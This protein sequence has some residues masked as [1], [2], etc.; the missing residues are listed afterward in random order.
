MSLSPRC[1]EELGCSWLPRPS[2]ELFYEN[3]GSDW[4][5]LDF[6]I[7]S[8]SCRDIHGCESKSYS[9]P[10]LP[11]KKALASP[12]DSLELDFLNHHEKLLSW[13]QS[14]FVCSKDI[15]VSGGRFLCQLTGCAGWGFWSLES[16]DVTQREVVWV[17]L[18]YCLQ[19]FAA[20]C[21]AA[22]DLEWLL[23]FH[24]SCQ[25][26]RQRAFPPYLHPA[27]SRLWQTNKQT[28]HRAGRIW[29]HPW[30]KLHYY[31]FQ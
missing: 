13:P 31:N 9:L 23:E 5:H 14:V 25:R 11:L 21:S 1:V 19:D 12:K 28:K 22:L 16:P 7:N 4:D 29:S 26:M 10:S 2:G 18:V 8:N 3:S 27:I 20:G 6:R 30:R 15:I 24:S 17:G